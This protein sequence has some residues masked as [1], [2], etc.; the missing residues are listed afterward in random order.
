MVRLDAKRYLVGTDIKFVEIKND[1]IMLRA[2][3]GYMKIEEHIQNKAKA[4]CQRISF[5][6]K[7]NNWDYREAVC[8]TIGISKETKQ[9]C[10]DF[11]QY[12]SDAAIRLFNAVMYC[13]EKRAE[14]ADNKVTKRQKTLAMKKMGMTETVGASLAAK[15]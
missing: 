6:M 3:G 7:K 2:G 4:E 1:T 12:T 14:R 11:R 15:F 8:Q 10:N 13:L 5:T 9:I